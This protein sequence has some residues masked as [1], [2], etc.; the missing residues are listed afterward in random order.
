MTSIPTKHKILNAATKLF[1]QHGLANVRLQMIADETGIS[2]GNLAYHF[3]NKEAIIGAISTN[4]QDEL[5]DILAMYRKRRD[6]LDFDL[7]LDHFYDFFITNP[8]YFMDVLDIKRSYPSLP[9]FKSNC[10]EKIQ[11][12]IVSRFKMNVET[13]LLKKEPYL[14]Y[15]KEESLSIWGYMVFLVPHIEILGQEIPS[16]LEFKRHIWMK[17]IPHLTDAGKQEFKFLISPILQLSID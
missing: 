9:V 3:K 5:L 6:L 4:L 14:D 15:Y 16:L 8:Y 10:A 1:N 17:F 7:Q 12:Q 13:G 11:S 2:I